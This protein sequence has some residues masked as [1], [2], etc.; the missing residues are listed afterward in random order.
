MGIP[1]RAS[2]QLVR[3]DECAVPPQ[4]QPTFGDFA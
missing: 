4:T 1:A 2:A 3:W